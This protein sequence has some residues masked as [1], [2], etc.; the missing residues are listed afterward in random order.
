MARGK[1]DIKSRLERQEQKILKM[2]DELELAKE[3]Y[4]KLQEEQRQEDI[5]KVTEA[6]LKS[7]RSMNEVL[8]FLKGKADI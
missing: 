7:R 5:K 1:M 8:D 2:T 6:Y 4:K 3:E